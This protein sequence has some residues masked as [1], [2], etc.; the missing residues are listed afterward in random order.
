MT[1]SADQAWRLLERRLEELVGRAADGGVRLTVALRDPDRRMLVGG[2]GPYRSASLI[3]LPVLATLLHGVDGGTVDLGRT[4]T[5]TGDE[6]ALVGGTGA[7]A[8]RDR[9]FPTE[10]TVGALAGLMVTISDNSATNLIIDGLGGFGPVNRYMAELGYR[11]FHLGRVMMAPVTGADGDNRF[12]PDELTDLLARILRDRDRDRDRDGGADGDV[13]TAD[14]AGV[15]LDLMGR[16]RVDTKFGAVIPRSVLANKTGE[17]DDVSHDAGY[18]LVP[19]ARPL[20]VTAATSF[21]A[22]H[23][24][25][26]A[27]RLVQQVGTAAYGYAAGSS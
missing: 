1:G 20:V 5:L 13:L 4:L 17:L 2:A 22:G 24:G 11:G 8:L 12:L 16:Q 25:Q 6:D 27:D 10:V 15:F 26:D 23:A 19:G 14:S 21:P 3:K 9:S 7:G 18:L